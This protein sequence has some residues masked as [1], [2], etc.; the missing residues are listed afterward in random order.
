MRGASSWSATCGVA[1][2]SEVAA[3]RGQERP[4]GGS[5]TRG[6]YVAWDQQA[7]ARLQPPIP[8]GRDDEVIQQL[9]TGTRLE[10]RLSRGV[11][12]WRDTYVAWVRR[13]PRLVDAVLVAALLL[14]AVPHVA[15]A[16]GWRLGWTLMLTPALLLPLVWRRLAPFAV[17]LVI[18]AAALVQALTDLPLTSDVALLVAFY[19]V[20]AYEPPRRILAAAVILEAGSVLAAIRYGVRIDRLI[21]VWVFIS[22]LVTAAGLI[23]YYVRTRRAYL[24]SLVGRAERLERE[25]DREA[26]L[27]ASAERARIAREMHDI[28]AH[29]LA[30]MIALADG[31]AYTAR[32]DPGQAVAIMGQVSGTGRSA[33][34]EMRRLLGVMRQPA[35]VVVGSVAPEPEHAP[36]PTLADVDDLLATVRATGLPTSLTVVGH[37]LTLPPSVQL[38]LYRVIQ[39]ALTNTLKHAAAPSA[40][41][42]L[43]CR[44]GAVELEV[45]DDGRPAAAPGLC[46]SAVAGHGIV[47]MRERAAVFGGQVFAGPCSG[48]GWRVHMVLPLD[49][50]P[51][52]ASGGA[53]RPIPTG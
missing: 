49:P 31:A 13:H 6:Q 53:A 11:L 52:E 34:T 15:G 21:T 37:P 46:G 24:A 8:E 41:V 36:Q 29:N 39:E 25:R 51:A 9:R 26:L 19:T 47:G 17:F 10:D 20:V 23:G 32:A 40:H 35:A 22:A 12:A 3:G 2:A 44:P 18:A 42:R 7:R 16:R 27:A 48:G 14:L 50:A 43:A 1:A 33:L 28:V 5:G 30:V 38:A 4:S 45:T